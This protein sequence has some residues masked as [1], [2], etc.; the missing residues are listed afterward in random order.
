MLDKYPRGGIL[1]AFTMLGLSSPVYPQL[2]TRNEV[3]VVVYG[4]HVEASL[5]I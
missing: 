1:F 2:G 5:S 4:T 3:I